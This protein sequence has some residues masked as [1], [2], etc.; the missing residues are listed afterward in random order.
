MRE[1]HEDLLLRDEVLLVHLELVV[2][3]LAAPR[4]GEALPE[5][6]DLLLDHA[7]DHSRVGEDVLQLG[8]LLDQLFV[9]LA[10][11]PALEAGQ[12]AEAE[13]DDGL[14]L[15]FGEAEALFQRGLRGLLVLRAT[16]DRDRLVEIVEDDDQPFEDVRPVTR[17]LELVPGA[18]GH[19]VAPV[20]DVVLEHRLEAQH[21]RPS[22]DDGEHQRAERHLQLGVLVQVVEDG[23]RPRVRLQLDDDAHLVLAA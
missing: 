6:D 10:Q 4:V 12:P 23:M 18:P 8:D 5:P 13:V 7:V 21:L 22:V 11:L 16:D 17:G 1:G 14:R 19:H 3:D 2:A 15:P 20:R 9:F